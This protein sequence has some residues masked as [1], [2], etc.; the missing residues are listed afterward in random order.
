MMKEAM[1]ALLLTAIL[2]GCYFGERD[3]DQGLALNREHS[4]KKCMKATDRNVQMNPNS[5]QYTGLRT[6]A[7]IDF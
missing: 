1:R 2:F 6:A 5:F 7:V 3:V 4:L